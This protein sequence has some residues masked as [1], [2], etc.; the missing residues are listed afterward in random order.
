V[1]FWWVFAG[2]M[3]LV[4]SVMALLR[5]ERER[6]RE[7]KRERESLHRSEDVEAKRES[8]DVTLFGDDIVHRFEDVLERERYGN[9][10][11]NYQPHWLIGTIV[12]C[13][14]L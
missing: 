4:K 7:R 11:P 9:C 3:G 14:R 8:D 6:E 10:N 2:L 5:R 13:R 1:D 12:V